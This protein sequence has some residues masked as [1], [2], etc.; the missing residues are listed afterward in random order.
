MSGFT[1]QRKIEDDTIRGLL[2]C[3]FEGGS[4]YWY[5]ID[6]Y[7]FAEG[8]SIGDFRDGARFCD[9]DMYWHPSQL[10]PLHEGCA[11]IV[12]SPHDNLGVARKV[13]R[14]DRKAIQKGLNV[15]AKKYPRHMEHALSE[16]YDAETG[17]VFLQCCLFGGL[18]FG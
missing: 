8:F 6:E 16:D 18:V 14:L 17:D 5:Q 4:N 9:P 2:C 10:I 3:A 7:D 12:S 11:V 13:H 15:M 1:V